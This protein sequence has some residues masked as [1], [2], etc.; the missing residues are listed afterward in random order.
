MNFF[1][2]NNY[3]IIFSNF[4]TNNEKILI[5]NF[6]HKKIEKYTI[7]E[8][9]NLLDVNKSELYNFLDK[10]QTKSIKI[11]INVLIIKTHFFMTIRIVFAVKP[12]FFNQSLKSYVIF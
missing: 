3:K 12:H 2:F 1:S 11:D 10:F 4:P 8:L 6:I 7:P 5:K 9:L